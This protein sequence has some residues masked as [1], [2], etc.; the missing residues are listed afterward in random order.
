MSEE[1]V[2]FLERLNIELA[3]FDLSERE[4]IHDIAHP[5]I[6]VVGAPRSGTT[7]LTQFIAYAFDAG[8]ICNL[9]ARFWRAP[10]TGIRLAREVLGEGIRPGWNSLIGRTE[11]TGPRGIHEY[12]YFWRAMFGFK[13]IDDLADLER[14]ARKDIDWWNVGDALASIQ[15]ELGDGPVVMKGIYPAYFPGHM[16]STLGDNLIW[17]NVERDP[18]DTCISILEARQV[19]FGD[20]RAW[21]GWYPPEPI[22]SQVKQ[23]EDPYKQ[24]VVQVSYF[25]R[26]YRELATLTLSLEDLC[27]STRHV[28]AQ[29]GEVCGLEVV[30]QPPPGALTFHNYQED[31]WAEER[32]RF[33]QEWDL[34]E[35]LE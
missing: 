35:A 32:A 29:I 13:T 6:F 28:L 26:V 34:W 3:E 19:K 11:A 4:Q 31:Y 1:S 24:V 21:L 7:L 5:F 30:R 10:V 14:R 9:A 2:G 16:Q 8:Y 22:L 15:H 17:L 12:G 33:Q 23:I 18:L 25:R 20:V 27:I